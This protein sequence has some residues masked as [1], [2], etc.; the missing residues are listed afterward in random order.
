VSV[1]YIP[2]PV[3]INLDSVA[4]HVRKAVPFPDNHSDVINDILKGDMP[5]G[6]VPYTDIS[7]V[8]E[9]VLKANRFF[10]G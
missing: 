4:S 10:S 6:M 9:H 7:V 5:V 1:T 2:L 3:I 8:K